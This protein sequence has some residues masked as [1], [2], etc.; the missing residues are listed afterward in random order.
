[1]NYLELE[2]K[3]KNEIMGD[4]TFQVF[5]PHYRCFDYINNTVENF[6]WGISGNCTNGMT[7]NIAGKEGDE[8]TIDKIQSIIDHINK[9]IGNV[10]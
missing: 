6:E 7:A 4:W 2:Q 5:G 3:L 1:M 9:E 10:D 8:L